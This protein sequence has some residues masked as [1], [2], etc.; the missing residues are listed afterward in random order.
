MQL[1][2]KKSL[3]VIR[4]IL[5]LL[6]STLAF[7]LKYALLNRDNLKRPIQMQLSQKQNKILNFS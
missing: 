5:R 3:I 2:W 1:S 4:N 6:F 7:G